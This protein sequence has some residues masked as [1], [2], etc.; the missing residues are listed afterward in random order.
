MAKGKTNAMRFLDSH[1]VPYEFISYEINDGKIDGISVAEK[2]KKD[3]EM[4]YKTLVLKGSSN[5]VY[6]FIVPVEKELDLKK[7]AKAAEEKKIEMVPVNDIQ[8]LTGYIR[9]GCSPLGMKK[10]YPTFLAQEA[11]DLHRIIVSGGRIGAQIELET[12][13]LIK[14][15]SAKLAEITTN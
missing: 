11:D 6:V 12:E 10:L 8:K 2:I 5:S 13:K 7:A 15:I 9:G 1:K 14:A 4:V 3:P